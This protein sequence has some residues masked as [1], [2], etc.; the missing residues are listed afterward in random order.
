YFLYNGNLDWD[1]MRG[2][3]RSQSVDVLIGRDDFGAGATFDSTWGVPDKE[4]FERVDREL[5]AARGPF[6]ATV[7]TLSNH[8]PF[9]LPR[10]LPSPET[11]AAGRYHDRMNGIRYA[12]W[13]IGHFFELARQRP[14]FANTLF[15]LVADHGFSIPPVLTDLNVLRFHVP[16]LFYAP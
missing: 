10:P 12:D 6:F 1:N 14:W 13:S 8:T 9:D 5:G 3:F 7:L 15:V 11:T 2:F 4:L 16:L